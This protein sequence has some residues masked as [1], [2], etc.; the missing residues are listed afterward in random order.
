MASTSQIAGAAML[1]VPRRW[2]TR[3]VVVVA[4]FMFVVDAF[5]VNVAIPSIGGWP[6][7][8]EPCC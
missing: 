1:V 2:W 7:A 8:T 4:Q 5:V 6:K 3:T